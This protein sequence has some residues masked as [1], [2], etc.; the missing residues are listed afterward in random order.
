M[1][2]DF[3]MVDQLDTG[4]FFSANRKVR[5]GDV[6]PS[7]RLRLDAL[8][9]YTQDVSNDD[10]T[11]AELSEETAWVV[12]RTHVDV[13]H[14]ASLGERLTL[15]TFCGA[16]GRRWADRRICVRGDAGAHYEV[17]TL[18]IHLDP[19]SGRPLA[20]SDQ[21]LSIYGSAAGDRTVKAKLLLPKYDGALVETSGGHRRWPTRS[22]DFDPQQHMNNAAYWAVFEELLAEAEC[23]PT[24]RA[25]VE[26][27]AG[28]AMD[29]TVDLAV[30][31][32]DGVTRVWWLASGEGV[33]CEVS[34]QPA[35]AASGA[36][37]PL[38]AASLSAASG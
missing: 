33:Q 12:R 28:I 2:G 10:T 16:L 7:G 8:N 14:H 23:P 19:G 9:R 22:V 20:L 25:T 17:A 21:F 24:F 31:V 1:S 34:V 35:V 15:T 29:A 6:T 11:D 4:R 32:D 27:G 36:V 38:S 18:W 5:L 3:F 30:V 13:H 37:E 26:Y